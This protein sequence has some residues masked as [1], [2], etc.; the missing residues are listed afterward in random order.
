[1]KLQVVL[2]GVV[3]SLAL[4]GATVTPLS[5]YVKEYDDGMYK[6]NVSET[7]YDF[8]DHTQYNVYLT[9]QMWLTDL[10]TDSHIWTHWLEVCI[11]KTIV[12]STTAY[13]WIDGRSTKSF[14]EPPGPSD[15]LLR[16]PCVTTNTL[17]FGLYQIPNEPVVYFSDPEL[18]PRTEDAM[19]AYTW[20]HFVNNTLEY[21]WLARMPMTKASIKA[22]DA[23]QEFW[24]SKRGELPGIERFVVSGASKRGWTTWMVGAMG[25]P[26]VA[27]IVPVVAPIANLVPQIN[28][29]YESYG[30][31]SFALVD[32]TEL[33][34]MGWLNTPTFETLLN[35]IDP[36]TYKDEMAAIP[37]YQVGASG[38]EF[39]MPDALQYYWDD[40]PGQK[41]YRI[42]PNAEH[43]L[44]GS[45]KDA[46][47]SSA[48]FLLSFKQGYN[49][50]LPEYSWEISE[51]GYT[52]TVTATTDYI[53]RV[54]VYVSK[55]NPNRD[56]RLIRCASGPACVNPTALWL[57]RRARN[58]GDGVY[59]YTMDTPDEGRYSAFFIEIDYAL[60]TGLDAPFTVTSDVSIVPKAMP[61]PPCDADTC[62]CEWDCA[63][64][65][66][67]AHPFA[68]IS[69]EDPEE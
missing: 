10:D 21:D 57:P 61:F 5:Y 15:G 54:R 23:A 11:P 1:M 48:N 28:E 67:I 31:F 62:A 65:D 34:L 50:T 51:D 30:G 32:Y 22:M 38:D 53:S 55:N 4:V 47:D 43:S 29:Q 59:S 35:P 58:V 14:D 7:V 17:S 19:I 64:T 27:A 45:I 37:K 3:A 9:S 8:D 46:I 12:D 20:A 66:I 44:V 39:F 13:L 60:P 69:S 40:L 63:D 56:W 33:G 49:I 24:D 6:W 68:G 25:D 18:R 2:M 41:H 16:R 52:I 42:L 26:R 36:L